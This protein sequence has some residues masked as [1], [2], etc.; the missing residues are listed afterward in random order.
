ML[1]NETPK[2]IQPKPVIVPNTQQWMVNIIDQ[3]SAHGLNDT[4]YQ[5]KIARQ[6]N[7]PF[8]IFV[9]QIY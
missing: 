7:Q 9:L 5:S 4:R 8:N 2:Q 1:I 3:S 6:G